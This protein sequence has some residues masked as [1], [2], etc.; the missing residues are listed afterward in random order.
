[1]LNLVKIMKFLS[2]ILM[3]RDKNKNFFFQSRVSR[4]E[5]EIESNFLVEQEKN[6]AN[7][8]E[9]SQDQEFS[10][11]FWMKVDEGR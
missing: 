6:E 3:L 2:F 8:P 4:R 5:R 10:L 7:S 1:M 11:V 9:I